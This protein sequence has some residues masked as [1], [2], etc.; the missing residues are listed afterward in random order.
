MSSTVVPSVA[1]VRLFPF[2]FEGSLVLPT[3]MAMSRP[4]L[5]EYHRRV[6]EDL[7]ATSI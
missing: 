3:S 6:T 2:P 7:F 4:S 1:E 5:P